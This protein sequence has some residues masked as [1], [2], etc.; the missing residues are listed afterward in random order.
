MWIREGEGL[1]ST[2]LS[3]QPRT[4]TKHEKHG[5]MKPEFEAQEGALMLTKLSWGLFVTLSVTK[6]GCTDAEAS[7]MSG[8]V[9]Q[10]LR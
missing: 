6:I 4:T 9:R 1:K 10:H 3:V 8:V 5:L 2:K 7:R